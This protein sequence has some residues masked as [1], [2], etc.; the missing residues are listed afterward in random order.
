MRWC[1]FLES[2]LQLVVASLLAFRFQFVCFSSSFVGGWKSN[3]FFCRKEKVRK[4][5]DIFSFEALGNKVSYRLGQPP[6]SSYGSFF[7]YVS[8]RSRRFESGFAR[9]AL[10]V[11]QYS[12]CQLKER[13]DRI[14]LRLALRPNEQLLVGRQANAGQQVDLICHL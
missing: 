4:K 8:H 1:S 2:H 11:C 13:G 10:S 5:L 14:Y 6:H 3:S 12:F 7:Y 9:L